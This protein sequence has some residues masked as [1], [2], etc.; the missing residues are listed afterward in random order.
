MKG[1]CVT[2]FISYYIEINILTSQIEVI[3]IIVCGFVFLYDFCLLKEG[4]SAGFELRQKWMVIE[5]DRR[6]VDIS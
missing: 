1:G 6:I 5:F 3:S 4:L 2:L